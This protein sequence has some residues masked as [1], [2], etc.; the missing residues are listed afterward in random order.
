M[1]KVELRKLMSSDVKDLAT[2]MNNN[3]IWDNLRDNIPFLYLVKDAQDF[4][5]IVAKKDKN[6]V[7]AIDYKKEFCG[8]LDCFKEK[9][10]AA[11]LLK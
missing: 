3:N 5:K 2:L 4:I 10:F 9:M 11:N 6:V 8:V 7:F 1:S